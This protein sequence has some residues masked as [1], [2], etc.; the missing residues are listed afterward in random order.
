M[1]ILRKL[2]VFLML[3]ALLFTFSPTVKGENIVHIYF[4]Y[5]IACT[6]CAKE[7]LALDD[8]ESRYT[9]IEV[10]RYEITSSDENEALFNAV[11]DV[12]D[13]DTLTPFTVVGGVAL[14]GYNAQI[15][16]NIEKLIARYS[17]STHVDIVAKVIHGEIV[18]ETDFDSLG[19]GP[20]DTINL[21]LI[22]EVSVDGLALGLIAA[23]IGFVDGFNP[24]AMWILVF[25]IT[26]FINA[27]NRKR[28]WFLG[29]TFLVTSAVVYF[30]FMVAWL[31]VAVSLSTIVWIRVLIGSFAFVFGT[32]NI[33]KYWLSRKVV[34]VGCEVTT[35][36]KR[37]KII[38]KIQKIVAEKSLVI[39]FFG[40][41][42]LAFTVNLIELAC[43]A[44]LP[45]T[46]TQLLAYYIDYYELSPIE[47]YGNLLIYI[48][49][50][51]L[52]D[53]VVFILAMI[54]FRVT[55]ISN[56]YVKVSHLVG[57]IIM[58]IIAILL[59]FFPHLLTLN[60]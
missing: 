12:F 34:E 47:Y 13:V 1:K 26:M 24:C 20:G 14:S 54:T 10:H 43:S 36:K 32:L 18:L 2:N 50:F 9:N 46:Y 52:D 17:V 37:D 28:M 19:F 4:F 33:R 45:L 8:L 40:I 3:F 58:I 39:A 35:D 11:R 6:N 44:G 31:S 15:K 7:N 57:G 55:G 48:L 56:R 42:A 59:I 25:L 5:D 38:A 30:L 23:L 49:F 51:L 29:V 53:L 27:K 41:I 16:A 22:G 60:F 21:P